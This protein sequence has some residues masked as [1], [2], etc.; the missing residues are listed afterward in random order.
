M[1]NRWKV[2]VVKSALKSLEKIPEPWNG[3]IIKAL[4]YLENNPFIGKKLWGEIES[5][6][7]LKIWP[8]RIIYSVRETQRIIYIEKIGHR[9]GVYK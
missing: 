2:I 4:H 9:Q 8:Y 7:K 1:N 3:R 5:K 6:R